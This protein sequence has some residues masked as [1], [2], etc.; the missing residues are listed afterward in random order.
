ME[1]NILEA[2][3]IL[4]MGEDPRLFRRED[5]EDGRQELLISSSHLRKVTCHREGASRRVRSRSRVGHNGVS[6]SSD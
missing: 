2:C 1:A 3:L 5:Q 4:Y 6:W